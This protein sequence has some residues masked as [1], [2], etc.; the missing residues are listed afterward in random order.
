MC[1]ADSCATQRTARYPDRTEQSTLT[2][3][4]VNDAGRHVYRLTLFCI[5]LIRRN[6]RDRPI[7][8]HKSASESVRR[9]RG[10]PGDNSA[11]VVRDFSRF[12][13]TDALKERV[14]PYANS[15]S[16]VGDVA[17]GQQVKDERVTTA[18]SVFARLHHQVPSVGIESER[19]RFDSAPRKIERPLK[20]VSASRS[21]HS[22]GR[23]FVDSARVREFLHAPRCREKSR[24]HRNDVPTRNKYVYPDRAFFACDDAHFNASLPGHT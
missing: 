18:R 4:L 15:M 22:F 2:R 24:A 9:A 17:G 13:A 11:N 14:R 21:R 5:A 6:N 8:E 1:P 12:G 23:P 3:P 16:S 10:R 7:G 20:N 19:R